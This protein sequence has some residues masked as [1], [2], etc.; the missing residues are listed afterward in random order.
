[1]K[2][3]DL[4]NNRTGALAAGRC[5]SCLMKLPVGGIYLRIRRPIFSEITYPLRIFSP[6]GVRKK[7]PLRISFLV[8]DGR[9]FHESL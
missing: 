8:A 1:M 2:K 9:K 4:K 6:H 3:A 7:F 5:R